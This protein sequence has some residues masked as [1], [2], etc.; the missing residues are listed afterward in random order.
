MTTGPMAVGGAGVDV[1]GQPREYMVSFEAGGMGL[2]ITKEAAGGGALVTRVVAGAPAERAGVAV[3][4][5]VC[6]VNGHP[7]HSYEQVMA[8]I[9]ASSRPLTITFRR[10]MEGMGNAPNP[11]VMAGEEGTGP[12][13]L[14][15]GAT[16]IGTQTW[17][18]V[19]MSAAVGMLDAA[20]A[21]AVEMGLGEATP[22]VHEEVY[23]SNSTPL[24]PPGAAFRIH[25]K[26]N[27]VAIPTGVAGGYG[28]S[29]AKH[30][31]FNVEVP[32]EGANMTTKKS[33]APTLAE[34]GEF[35]VELGEGELGMRLEERG[36]FKTVSVVVKTTEGGQ[37]HRL[38]VT[39]GCVLV[40][41]NGEEYLS[42]AHSVATLKHARRPIVARFRR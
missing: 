38:G 21:V 31:T 33:L 2:T 13:G 23:S 30:R 15:V 10:R 29:L 27:F 42:H 11:L 12:G 39:A 16:G 9:S 34:A 22:G 37:A 35:D 3:G 6:G 4:H 25:Q 24:P 18:E 19:G 32:T 36:S 40:G 8:S 41:L 17:A 28:N 14:R 7:R 5:R 1:R 20:N 26:T